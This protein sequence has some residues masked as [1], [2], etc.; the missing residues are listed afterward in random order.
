[1]TLADIV[2]V[3]LPLNSVNKTSDRRI[4]GRKLTLNPGIVLRLAN[5]T[6]TGSSQHQ[7]CGDKSINACLARLRDKTEYDNG[8]SG[9]PFADSDS[10]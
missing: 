10:Y 6:L 3:L 4:T 5:N 1:M 2:I 8:R 7:L 9:L